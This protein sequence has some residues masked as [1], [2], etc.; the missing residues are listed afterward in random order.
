MKTFWIV[1]AAVIVAI[2]IVVWA[3]L[4]INSIRKRK[5]VITAEQRY[6]DAVSY[7]FVINPSKPGAAQTRSYIE[8]FCKNHNIDDPVFIETQLDKDGRVCAQEAL[9]HNA[10]VVIAVGGD[11]TVRTVASAMAG[12]THAFGIIPIGTGNLFARN[13][14]IPVDN[15][16]AAMTIATSHGSRHVDMGRL[17]LLDSKEPDHKHGF[18]IIAGCGFDAMMIDDT[19]PDLKKSISWMAYFW[20]AIKHLF[21]SQV[22]GTAIVTSPDGTVATYENET[23]RTFMA[24][25]CGEI[26]GFT[27]MPGAQ[28]DDGILDFQTLDTHTGL[29][30]WVSLGIDVIH[31]TI[32][33]KPGGTPLAVQSTVKQYQGSRAEVI[34]QKAVLAEVDGDILEKSK[35]LE[36]TIEHNALI[37]RAP[38]LTRP[39]VTGTFQPI[40]APLAQDNQNNIA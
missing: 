40:T 5:Q 8:E 18:L 2:I 35:H 22:K 3:I 31:Q 15:I 10:D 29:L 30:G 27:L 34:L 17:A 1:F 9:D 23:F 36:F 32:S 12:T 14:G 21:E 4:A 7:A 37:V 20:G 6:G 26:P 38:D 11:G 19:D 25:N 33:R 13:L 28:Y 16:E 39:D 24:G